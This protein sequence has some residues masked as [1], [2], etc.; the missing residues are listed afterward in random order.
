MPNTCLGLGGDRPGRPM[1]DRALDFR[2]SQGDYFLGIQTAPEEVLYMV[3]VGGLRVPM[4]LHLSI[5]LH[6]EGPKHSHPPKWAPDVAK[7]YSKRQPSKVDNH[8]NL[9]SLS[10]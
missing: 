6:T 7:G 9:L 2:F 4:R 10:L 8:H 5:E 3:F 1:M